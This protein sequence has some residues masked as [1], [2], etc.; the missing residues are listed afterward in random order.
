MIASLHESPKWSESLILG[1]GTYSKIYRRNIDLEIDQLDKK[2]VLH[3]IVKNKRDFHSHIYTI[4]KIYKDGI[5]N[6]VNYAK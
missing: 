1:K 5:I 2:K 4:S 3:F 6:N